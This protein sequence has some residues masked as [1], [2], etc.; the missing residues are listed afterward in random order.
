VAIFEE[1]ATNTYYNIK[2][3]KYSHLYRKLKGMDALS[4]S[5]GL[6]RYVTVNAPNSELKTI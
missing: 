6:H 2:L 1:L 4:R 5:I 3:S